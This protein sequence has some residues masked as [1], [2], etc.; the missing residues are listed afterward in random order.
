[1]KLG[2]WGEDAAEKYLRRKGYTIM[3]RNFRCRFGEIDIIALNGN[4]L[5]FVEVK[6]RRNLNFGWPCESVTP[7]KI[8]HLKRAVACYASTCPAR[9]RGVRL[10]VV[11]ILLSEGRIRINHIENILG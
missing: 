2:A 3:E 7:E 8:R 6:T 1:M 5:V 10:D 9:Y 4:E 11:E